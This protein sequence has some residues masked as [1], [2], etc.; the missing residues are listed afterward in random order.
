MQHGSGLRSR[1]L[2]FGV[3]PWSRRPDVEKRMVQSTRRQTAVGDDE[4]FDAKF[5]TAWLCSGNALGAPG[6]RHRV[7]AYDHLI[8]RACAAFGRA[9][10]LDAS[11][12][13]GRH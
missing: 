12:I 5:A 7:V 1:P 3:T 4:R 9:S 13:C 2:R 6:F 8:L 11:W 10:A